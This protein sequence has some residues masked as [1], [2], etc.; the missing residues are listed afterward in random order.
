LN[1]SLQVLGSQSS[2]KSSVIEALVGREFLPRGTGIVTRR[3]LI[4]QLLHTPGDKEWAEFLHVP[5]VKFGSYTAIRDEISRAVSDSTCSS[6]GA[7][8]GAGAGVLSI[9]A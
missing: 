2:G 9:C 6:T 5:G 3:P 4:V 8:A 7:G 1:S